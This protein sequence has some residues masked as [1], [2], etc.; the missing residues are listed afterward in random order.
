MRLLP[1]VS[2]IMI[3]LNRHR[4]NTSVSLRTL[5]LPLGSQGALAPDRH[6]VRKRSPAKIAMGLMNLSL[7]M[8]ACSKSDQRQNV[9][10]ESIRNV[11]IKLIQNVK[12]ESIRNVKTV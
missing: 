4:N 3:P 9:K 5:C 1:D 6:W 11:K 7:A 12:T 8:Y 10:T 2:S